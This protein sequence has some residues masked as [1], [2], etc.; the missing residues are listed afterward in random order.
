MAT[1]MTP[2]EWQ[3][4]RARWESDPRDGYAWLKREMNLHVSEVAILKRARKDLWAKKANMK[5]V[6]EMAQFKADQKAVKADKPLSEAESVDIRA[7]I[8]EAHRREWQEHRE[9]F[10]LEAIITMLDGQPKTAMLTK[11]GEKIARTAKT[12]A[13]TIKH[14]QSGEREAW[15]LDALATD[16][17]AGVKTVE[18]LEAM[19]AA[20]MRK[21]DEMQTAV[22]K[23]RSGS[24]AAD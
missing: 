10:P 5:T 9:R 23:E 6:A 16:T 2:D 4:A 3:D 19:Y 11:D 20:A 24:D 13:E 21:S 1:K 8:L 22:E 17:T 18:E 12:V 15:G 7:N 14:R